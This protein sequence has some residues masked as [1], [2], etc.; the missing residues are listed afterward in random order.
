MQLVP[1]EF[2][3]ASGRK[4]PFKIECDGYN[5]EQ[6]GVI[7]QA[8]RHRLPPFCKVLG[9]PRGGLMLAKLLKPYVTLGSNCVLITDDVWTTG[10]SMRAFAEKNISYPYEWQGL[11][12]F[13]RG[14]RPIN[15]VAFMQLMV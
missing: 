14:Q 7:A 11:V 3:A 15:V 4:L 13:S 10:F 8:C 6:W 1:G 5:L 12:A 9:V 2:T